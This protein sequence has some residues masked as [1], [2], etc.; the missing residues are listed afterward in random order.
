MGAGRQLAYLIGYHRKTAPLLACPR[1]FYRRIECQ[2]IGLLRNGGDHLGD[3]PHLFTL[4]LQQPHGFVGLSNHGGNLLHGIA[5]SR[6]R[7][8]SLTGLLPHLMGSIRHTGNVA[9][10]ITSTH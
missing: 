2:Q 4:M 1:R 6:Q 10:H 7:G 5:H 9:S 8:L 3:L